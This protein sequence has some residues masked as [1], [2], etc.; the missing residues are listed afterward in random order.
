MTKMLR[1]LHL[2][3]A[4]NIAIPVSVHMPVRSKIDW[5]CLVEIGWPDGPWSRNVSGVDAIDAFELALR[6]VGTELYSSKWHAA[7]RLVWL[8]PGDGYGFPVPRTIGDLLI[9][10]DQKRY[11]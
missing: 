3:D 1:L 9:G 4:P 6:M 11:G 5:S 8:A 7:K 2:T 10:Q